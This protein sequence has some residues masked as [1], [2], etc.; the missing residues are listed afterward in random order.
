MDILKESWGSFTQKLSKVYLNGYGHPSDYSKKMVV[1]ILKGKF[2]GSFSLLDLGCGNAHLAGFFRDNQLPVA[3]TGVDF[4]DALLNAARE[5]NPKDQFVCDDVNSL[6][7][8]TKTYDVALYSHVIEM[9]GEPEASL[10]AACK[11]AP[12]IMIRFFEPPV[13]N[14]DCVEIKEM[15]VGDNKKVPYLRRKMSADY[16]RMICEKCGVKKVEVYSDHTTKD[17]IHIWI[18]EPE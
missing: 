18:M 9:L 16:Y 7:K 8:L 3:Y 10:M 5:K 13:F 11:K 4:S 1:D 14:S 17:E 2:S 15:D 6:E 12:L